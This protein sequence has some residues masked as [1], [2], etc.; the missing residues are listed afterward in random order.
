DLEAFR[1]LDVF[2]VDAA[3]GGLEGRHGIDDAVDLARVD[4]DV[5]HVD[6]GKLL[7]Q[8]RLAFHYRLRGERSDVAETK[9]GS[10]V[11]DDG[12][13]VGTAGVVGRRRGIGMDGAAWWG[14]ARRIRECKV[15]QAAARLGRPD[16]QPPRVGTAVE[17][18]A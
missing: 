16:R 15:A 9:H 14:H 5:E 18:E 8:H 13:K 17:K 11:R 10:A 6:A 1:R 4:L 7:E 3:E 2:Q 12:D